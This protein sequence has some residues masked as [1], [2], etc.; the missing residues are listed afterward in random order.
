MPKDP[1]EHNVHQVRVST[2]PLTRESPATR[3]ATPPD[4]QPSTNFTGLDPTPSQPTDLDMEI[5]S[6]TDSRPASP[7]APSLPIIMD[8]DSQIGVLSSPIYISSTDPFDQQNNIV[9]SSLHSIADWLESIKWD[10]LFGHNPLD[11]ATLNLNPL[12]SA[13]TRVVQYLNAGIAGRSVTVPELQTPPPTISR[14]PSRQSASTN[15]AFIDEIIRLR[16][17]NP[18]LSADP[19]APP[20]QEAPVVPSMLSSQGPS[21]TPP[22]ALQL[23]YRRST[24]DYPPNE[25]PEEPEITAVRSA[26]GTLF[27]HIPPSSYSVGKQHIISTVKFH[28]LPSPTLMVPLSQLNN[29]PQ[30]SRPPRHGNLCIFYDPPVWSKRR[31]P[32]VKWYTWSNTTSS[33]P[34]PNAPPAS[35]GAT[36]PCFATPPPI[37][38]P[39]AQAST[40][41]K[42]TAS[43]LNAA[44]ATTPPPTASRAPIPP[45]VSPVAHPTMLPIAPAHST[46][47]GTTPL[48]SSNTSQTPWINASLTTGMMYRACA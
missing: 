5:L 37:D 6:P 26:L 46:K 27:P 48:G 1:G 14:S 17:E 2:S 10:T 40:Q 15:D 22:H 45:H 44:M 38:V 43:E 12:A 33:T 18:D 21:L 24:P 30:N 4:P 25:A 20:F 28:C 9:T 47:T 39:T 8:E 32:T 13:A 42:T 23:L 35:D 3:R 31:T 7:T 36:P 11:A 19:T 29:T 34:R 16:E 41:C